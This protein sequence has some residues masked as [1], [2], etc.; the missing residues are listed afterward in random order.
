MAERTL[1]LTATTTPREERTSIWRYRLLATLQ[2]FDVAT[3]WW[4]LNYWE[5]R[6]EGNPIV[7]EA[8]HLSGLPLAMVA[9]LVFKLSVVYVLWEK[10]T[11]VKLMSAIYT[12][13]VVNNL[14]FLFLWLVAS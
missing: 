6:A 10:Q 7:A 8:I 1:T 5:T 2:F 14:L 4:I 11:G 3:T 13:V 12:L 9:L